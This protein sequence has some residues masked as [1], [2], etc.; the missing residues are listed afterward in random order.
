MDGF[1]S[2]GSTS[3]PHGVKR[4][5]DDD[6]RDEQRLAKRLNLLNLGMRCP[7]NY[8]RSPQ[9]AKCYIRQSKMVESTCQ[10]LARPIHLANPP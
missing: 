2:R 5:A 9:I 4:H 6:L 1:A 7:L 10:P 8:Q 3:T